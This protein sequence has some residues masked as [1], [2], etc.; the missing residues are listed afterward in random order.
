MVT[1]RAS[2]A[3]SAAVHT[4][5][6]DSAWQRR[7]GLGFRSNRMSLRRGRSGTV[8]EVQTVSTIL[9]LV[10]VAGSITCSMGFRLCCAGF[11][12]YFFRLC[13]A[14][15]FSYFS[16]DRREKIKVVNEYVC[17][18]RRSMTKM[19]CFLYTLTHLPPRSRSA[20]NMFSCSPSRV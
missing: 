8:V 18:L 6:P 15:F 13:C 12:S 16:C 5:Q 17:G 7:R 10:H 20:C 11:F 9:F 3:S 19:S 1:K 14:G 2:R 4:L